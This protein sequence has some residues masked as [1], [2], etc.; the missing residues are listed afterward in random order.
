MSAKLSS[1]TP[2]TSIANLASK[3]IS[4]IANSSSTASGKNSATSTATGPTTTPLPATTTPIDDDPDDDDAGVIRCI[5]GFTEDDGFTIQCESCMVWQHAVCVGIDQSNVPE[6]YLCEECSPRAVDRK[7]ASEIQRR[8]KESTNRR[9]ERSPKRKTT[10]ASRLKKQLGGTGAGGSNDKGTGL[11]WST[12]HGSAGSRS[13]SGAQDGHSGLGHGPSAGDT[14]AGGKRGKQ[15]HH[16]NHHSTHHHHHHH[17]HH[18]HHA[19]NHNNSHGAS[20]QLHTGGDDED[21]IMESDSQDELDAYHFEFSSID[22]NIITSKDVHEVFRQVIAQ[23]RQAQSRKRSLSLTSGVKLQQL[24]DSTIPPAALPTIQ[25]SSDPSSF[26]SSLPPRPPGAA[27][28]SNSSATPISP[29]ESNHVASSLPAASDLPPNVVSM[30]RE[31]L[32]RPLIKTIVKHILPSSKSPHT[33]PSPQYGLFAESN[34][35]AG[36]FMLEY[37]GEVS[38]KST[39]I[40]DPINQYSLLATPKPYVLFHPHVDLAVDA[41]RSGNEARFARRSCFPNTEVKSIVVP[42]MQDQT[43]HL[44]LFAR[45]E[46]AKGDEITL[47]WDWEASHAAM[48]SI[49]SISADKTMSKEEAAEAVRDLR[50]AKYLVAT[51]LLAMTDCAC[52][53]REKCVLHKM[54]KEGKVDMATR[55]SDKAAAAKGSR[56]KKTETLRQRYGGPRDSDDDK[57]SDPDSDDTHR[58]PPALMGRQKPSVSG[59]SVTRIAEGSMNKKQRHNGHLSRPSTTAL[60][61]ASPDSDSDSDSQRRRKLNM[62]ERHKS[63]QKKD[64]T[65]AAFQS[66]THKKTSESSI[67]TEAPASMSKTHE[68]KHAGFTSPQREKVKSSDL[69]DPIPPSPQKRAPNEDD[70][71]SIGNSGAESDIAFNPNR[72]LAHTSTPSSSRPRNK[73]VKSLASGKDGRESQ[74][75][76]TSALSTP[77]SDSDLDTPTS[78]SPSRRLNISRDTGSRGRKPYT[79]T[80][81][82]MRMEASSSKSGRH[83]RSIDEKTCGSR[84]SSVESG[85]VGVVGS[86]SDEEESKKGGN[87]S[88]TN[89]SPSMLP[90]KKVWKMIYL[91]QRAIAE[92]DA[93]NKAEEMK[94]KAV[95]VFD[96]KVEDDEVTGFSTLDATIASVVPTADA[97]KEECMDPTPSNP[98]S[99]PP[100]SMSI[101]AEHSKEDLKSKDE[102]GQEKGVESSTATSSS[103]DSSAKESSFAS[104]TTTTTKSISSSVAHEDILNLFQ[105]DVDVEMVT[106]ELSEARKSNRGQ[107]KKSRGKESKKNLKSL[108]STTD[109]RTGRAILQP[110]LINPTSSNPSA[111]SDHQKSP[112][113]PGSLQN[114]SKPS[115]TASG[116]SIQPPHSD[117]TALPSMVAPNPA[118]NQPNDT[119]SNL[120]TTSESQ[121]QTFGTSG[122]SSSDTSASN[123]NVKVEDLAESRKEPACA[124]A[125]PAVIAAEGD[126]DIDMKDATPSVETELQKDNRTEKAPEPEP[127]P[128]VAPKVKMSLQEYVL[129]RQEASQRL[130]STP[131]SEMPA[132]TSTATG[133]TSETAQQSTD[134]EMPLA[135]SYGDDTKSASQKDAS[136]EGSKSKLS[137]EK[138]YFDIGGGPST[139]LIGLSSGASR[140]DSTSGEY[141]PVQPAQPFSPV[142]L[143]SAG[144]TPFS[145]LSLSSSPNKAVSGNTPQDSSSSSSSLATAAAA[146]RAKSPTP[147]PVAPRSLFTTSPSGPDANSTRSSGGR[148]HQSYGQQQQTSPSSWKSSG[149][150]TGH[151]PS[152]QPL[153]NL[154]NGGGVFPRSS[155]SNS[156]GGPSPL[157]RPVDH[158]DYPRTPDGRGG[159]L[160]STSSGGG[161][162]RYYG[163]PPLPD[164]SLFSP[165]RER[166]LSLSSGNLPG[167][168][169]ESG[170]G[171]GG[172][173]GYPAD[174]PYKRL[175]GSG[176]TSPTGPG[177][178][179]RD[180]YKG[181]SGGEDRARHRSMNGD[182]W[183]GIRGGPLPPPRDRERDRDRDRD[184]QQQQQFR[185]RDMVMMMR[186]YDYRDMRD[187]DHR[188]RERE[189]ERD[190]DMR[191][192]RDIRDMRDMRDMRDVRDMRDIRDMRDE[193]DHRDRERDRDRERRDYRYDRRDYFGGSSHITSAGG[194]GNGGPYGSTPG[195]SRGVASSGGGGSSNMSPGSIV[196]GP[197]SGAGLGSHR[198]GGGPPT[199]SGPP[200]GYSRRPSEHYFSHG[201]DEPSGS[202]AGN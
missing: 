133:T 79:T 117:T 42:G 83:D 68:R 188:D 47:G 11:S 119:S 141:F 144:P 3:T 60:P 192:M 157:N 137:T 168:P 75:D 136:Q 191:D 115:E 190:R 53:N 145:N 151:P 40:T 28:A 1:V 154:E 50:K 51:T 108:K 160:G 66:T 176:L 161:S 21:V 134:V 163:G 186:E 90:C 97:V 118:E 29:T 170:S 129:K 16:H 80:A 185:E 39:Y 193:R 107:D 201:Q 12:T 33:S 2:S 64:G 36:R 114:V 87:S 162:S 135:G 123:Q 25:D 52:D 200:S 99:S 198:G 113:K 65:A 30:E 116:K 37:K 86:L 44:G 18:Q 182:E 76:D 110:V 128:V 143:S 199:P 139:P 38:L 57:S 6:N 19:N 78:R 146:A 62:K 202:G 165:T 194:G 15:G 17:H 100:S 183:G 22:R 54:L 140:S 32:A 196:Y 167:S 14:S 164:R 197:V 98:V 148:H 172:G 58:I 169:Y 5:C 63:P 10:T 82:E 155:S 27:V 125:I 23:F 159:P 13:S 122:I 150:P 147:T 48:R 49:K 77:T 94:R 8:R 156:L 189:R 181:V 81:R 102:D 173:Y 69:N 104:T 112:Q 88:A 142:T 184:Q 103:K 126:M 101:D 121:E 149:Y 73:R 131:S 9:R 34:I 56:P 70:I 106:A 171:G 61:R 89:A 179:S 105:D 84:A 92:Q 74:D 85:F 120:E 132:S 41:R 109:S 187:R 177:G 152:P 55:E 31:S 67:E 91:K 35:G 138:G 153:S 95:E 4:R 111:S 43:V 124:E 130:G 166:Q 195:G 24:I 178:S 72:T 93:R 20:G 180:Y 158:R 71:V 174:D 59:A 96:L 46:I 26:G 127:E 45:T 7:R 175:S